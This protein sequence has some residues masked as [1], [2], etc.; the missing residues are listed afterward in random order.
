[1]RH[2][3]L[4]FPQG[5]RWILLAWFCLCLFS[6]AVLWSV[7][8]PLHGPYK[9]LDP[10]V[11]KGVFYRQVFWLAIGFCALVAASRFPLRYLDNI[12]MPLFLLSVLLLALI[13]MPLLIEAVQLASRI[14]S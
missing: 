9:E 6:L 13:L 7:T 12:S 1:M 2:L 11:S 4:L 5:D 14:L 3:S 10:G 8:E